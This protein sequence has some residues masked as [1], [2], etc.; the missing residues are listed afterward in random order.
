MGY[1]MGC[2]GLLRIPKYIHDDSPPTYSTYAYIL[3]MQWFAK[4]TKVYSR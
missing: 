2:I 4:N 3:D 1:A